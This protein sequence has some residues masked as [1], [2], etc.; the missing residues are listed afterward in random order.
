MAIKTTQAIN[1]F[2]AAE[3]RLS[4]N[5]DGQ[6]RL[7]VRIGINHFE[8][9]DDGTFRKL[10]P[11]YHN[12]VQFGQGAERSYERFR[13]G[14]D[15]VAQ[16]YVRQYT[17][18]VDGEERTDEQFVAKRLVHDP[19]TTTYE[20]QRKAPARERDSGRTGPDG[21]RGAAAPASP[22]STPRD[23]DV[24]RNNTTR[25]NAAEPVSPPPPPSPPAVTR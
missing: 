1:G 14:D 3:P 9:H 19:N 8:R 4:F 13:R 17:R 21:A 20:V 18:N 12:L 5:D 24:T 15:I 6:A 23:A 10:D 2:V 11:T 7:Y 25:T 22:A 16:G